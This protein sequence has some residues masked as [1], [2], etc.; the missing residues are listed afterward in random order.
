MALVVCPQCK[1]SFSPSHLKAIG[2]AAIGAASG[3]FLGA[4]LGI[5]AGPWDL[6]EVSS[7]G[8]AD[9]QLPSALHVANFFHCSGRIL[10]FLLDSLSSSS[11]SF[12]ISASITLE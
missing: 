2:G 9:A 10:P 11:Y 12:S 4:R 1:H 7:A 3:V 6:L 8:L 5:V